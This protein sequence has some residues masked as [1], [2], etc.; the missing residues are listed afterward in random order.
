MRRW[1]LSFFGS[2]LLVSATAQAATFAF[3]APPVPEPSTLLMLGSGAALLA[4]VRRKRGRNQR[5]TA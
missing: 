3:I 1:K 4:F 5:P 2:L